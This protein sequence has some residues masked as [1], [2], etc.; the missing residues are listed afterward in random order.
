MDMRILWCGWVGVLT[1]CGAVGAEVSDSD[2]HF[3]AI[4]KNMSAHEGDLKVIIPEGIDTSAMIIEYGRYGHGLFMNSIRGEAG[5]REYLIPYGPG[6][7]LKAF[8]YCPGY[9]IAWVVEPNL[10]EP[11]RPV[12]RPV[13][14]ATMKGI[15]TDGKST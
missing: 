11:W 7:T 8:V 1:V 3:R 5:K 9:Q 15:L 10:N 6:E 4:M 13:A 12:F 2:E 14:A